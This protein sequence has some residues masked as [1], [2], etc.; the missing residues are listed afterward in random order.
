MASVFLSYDRD[1]DARA[2]PIAAHLERAGHSVWWDRQIKGGGEFSAEIEAALAE[3]DKVLVLWSQRSVRSAW[4]RDEAAV[5]RERGCLVPATI[6][7]TA[8]PLGF[9]QFQTI[10]LS[11]WKGRGSSRELE[12]LLNAVETGATRA[13]VAP[14]EKTRLIPRLSRGLILA[15][16][17]VLAIVVAGLLAWQFWPA[18][19]GGTPTFAIV[20][21]DS[22]AASRQLATDVIARVASMDDRSGTDFR[23][24]DAAS[25]QAPSGYALRVSSAALT[26]LSSKDNSI[27]WSRP[28]DLSQANHDDIS[29]IVSI[30]AQRALSCTADAVSYRRETIDQEALKT[31]LTGCTNFDDAYGTNSP[32]NSK[33]FEN[34]VAKAPHFA[35][36]WSKLFAV[37]TD[38][39]YS[40]D[41]DAIVRIARSQL[42]RARQLGIDVPEAYAVEA[43]LLSPADFTGMFRVL[44][45]G[46]KKHP[47]SAFLFSVHG[48]RL[49]NVG[50]MNEAVG[51][52]AQAVQ[53]D[54]LSPA[55]QA[56]Y[57]SLLAYAGRS[58]TAYAQLGK[59]ERLW[60]NSSTLTF[61]R[62]RMD[63]RFGDPHEAKQLTLKNALQYGQDPAQ[64]KFIEARI[65]PTPQ[66]VEAAIEAERKLNRQFPPFI[67]SLIQALAYF[68]RKDEAIDLMVNYPGGASSEFVLGNA[69]VLF[70]PYMRDVWRD[71]RSIAGAARM[72]LLHYWKVSGHWPD[73]C[74]DPTL[75]YD[76]KKE[77][78]KY[79]V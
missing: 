34:V 37:Y 19:A 50:R 47:D 57:A 31:Y 42:E 12:E 79:K 16:G 18:G 63:L 39:L 65:N 23:V 33:L 4:V 40:G 10:D 35:P 60:P 22:S 74:F 30:T 69:E 78:A 43:G 13:P 56:S 14:I 28:L 38:M 5:G 49:M 48:E 64:E 53:F 71:P 9:R 73:F 2:R 55:Y 76:C 45:E 70:R 1:D 46:I 52:A 62:F 68:G 32:A 61:A 66:N 8:A 15:A 20:A 6:D 29:Q 36:A 44:E 59:A 11:H 77:A 67:A 21:A 58:D 51:D 75:P 26:L 24:V 7:G 3:A 41:R 25:S 54:P 72:G 27:A 17:T